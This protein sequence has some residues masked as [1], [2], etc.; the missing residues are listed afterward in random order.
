MQRVFVTGAN[1]GI[2]LELV[3]QMLLRGDRVFATCRQPE[4]ATELNRLQ[5]NHNG[6][7]TVLPLDVANKEAIDHAVSTVRGFA[8]G[9]DALFNNAGVGGGREPL[10]QIIENDLVQTYR[11]NAVAPLM[12]AQALL[13]LLEKGDRPAIVNITSRMGSIDDN[14][15]G[16]YYAYR[17]SKAALNM[18]NKSL[19]IDLA[20]N[21]II[22]V[23][24]HPG[25]VQTDMGGQGAPLPVSDSVK[26]ILQVIDTLSR[27][28]TGKFL[29]WK[30]DV[31]PW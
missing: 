4:L 24:I 23:V 9:L 18:L 3:R 7:L 28:D 16:G 30:G 13:P 26:G 27:N 15:S 29:D 8:D 25:W 10:G 2:G 11:V 31:I 6:I 17:A 21:S 1:R 5:E 14:G 22:S 19:A 20:R 12:I